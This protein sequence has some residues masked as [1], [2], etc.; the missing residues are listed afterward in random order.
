MNAIMVGVTRAATPH[1]NILKIRRPMSIIAR[2]MVPVAVEK[3]P[4]NSE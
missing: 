2:V 3:A 4:M 1:P